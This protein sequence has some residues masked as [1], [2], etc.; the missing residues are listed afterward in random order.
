MEFEG[1][2]MAKSTTMTVRIPS[3]V[4]EKLDSLARDM[5]RSKSYLAGE[6]IA[7]Y[8]ER[9]AWQVARIKAA[10]E[11]AKSGAPGVPHEEVVRWLQSLGTD[12]ELPRP[13]P[14]KP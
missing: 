8:V 6:A 1:A 3:E 4:S 2:D 7:S 12:Q 11:E 10:L 14:E 9:A 13:T 5:K